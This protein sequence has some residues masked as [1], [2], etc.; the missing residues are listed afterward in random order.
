MP[1]LHIGF[2]TIVVVT[3]K[4]VYTYEKW[5]F[6]LNGFR[7]HRVGNCIL[8]CCKRMET[9]HQLTPRTRFE[10]PGPARDNFGPGYKIYNG[11]LPK[12]TDCRQWRFQ[13][14]W[15]CMVGNGPET[16]VKICDACKVVYHRRGL[17]AKPPAA[18]KFKLFLAKIRF[19]VIIFD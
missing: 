9:D 12:H 13:H 5:S 16:F 14:F 19:L 6:T 18:G 4:C 3:T 2:A 8:F 1:C 11:P 7:C 17:G 15:K 10:N